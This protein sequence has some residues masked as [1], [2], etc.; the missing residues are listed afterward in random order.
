MN[1]Y[2]NQLEISYQQSLTEL[3]ECLDKVNTNLTKSLYSNSSNELYDV[4]RDLYAQ[5]STAK[6]AISRLPINQMELSGTYKFLSQASDYSQYIAQKIESGKK[7]SAE[8]HK[9]IYTLLNYAQKFSESASNMVKVVEA[10]GKITE[11]EVKS[12]SDLNVSALSNSFSS[13]A[14]TFDDYPTLLYD[15]PFSDQVLDKKSAFLKN[16]DTKTKSQC[17]NIAAK[18][19][20]VNTNKISFEADEDSNIP[21]YTF[22]SGR[23]TVSVTKQG[24]YIKSILY[25]GLIN[26]SEITE[27][28]A[29]NIAQD[30][31]A[32]IGFDNMSRSYYTT[33]N[34]ICTI[35][36]VYCKNDI[37][38]YSDLIKIGV[39]LNDGAI[40]SLDSTTYLTNHKD[41]SVFTPKINAN[42]ARK[43]ISPYLVVESTKKCIIPKENG[44]EVQ[45]YEFTCK[46]NDTGEDALIYINNKT[47]EEEDIMILLY[48]DNGTLV[49]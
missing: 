17:Q 48:S 22:K 10:G 31:L 47:G 13:S 20:K 26:N 5:C 3:S 18:A 11:N 7:I 12:A 23:Y 32:S 37:F 9:N 16:E 25:S 15:G 44:T 36:F 33:D 24:G 34:N 14:K 27:K 21:C 6:N 35:N 4:S 42:T 19:L 49:K 43:K 28:N 38:C 1:S 8:E 41:R 2:K 30:Y 39:S 40:V 46:S 29:A 45:C